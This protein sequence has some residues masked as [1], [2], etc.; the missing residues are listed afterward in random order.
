MYYEIIVI[1]VVILLILDIP[2]NVKIGAILIAFAYYKFYAP[3][4]VEIEEAKIDMCK[5]CV[6]PTSP[7]SPSAQEKQE[8]K[9]EAPIDQFNTYESG[10]IYD[11]LRDEYNIYRAAEEYPRSIGQI[12]PSYS[13]E[14][15]ESADDSCARRQ[16]FMQNRSKESMDNRARLNVNS[17]RSYFGEEQENMENTSWWGVDQEKFY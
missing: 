9:G 6:S 8:K 2:V 16:M 5:L 10:N 11:D 7:A 17:F 14:Y 15:S 12:N 3:P 4:P 1:A 13:Q